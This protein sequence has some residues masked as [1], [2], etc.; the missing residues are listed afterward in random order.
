MKWV[1]NGGDQ[2]GVQEINGKDKQDRV[3]DDNVISDEDGFCVKSIDASLN[4]YN[5]DHIHHVNGNGNWE[6]LTGF[7]RPKC[8]NKT[9]MIE[10]QN[11]FPS[12]PG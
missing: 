9:P 6:I 7:L 1:E 5:S 8:N 4:D 11:K 12:L 3:S 2:E 10:W